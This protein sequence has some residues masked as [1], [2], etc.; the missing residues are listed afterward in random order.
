MSFILQGIQSYLDSYLP[1]NSVGNFFREMTQ[2]STAAAAD[3][4][5]TAVVTALGLYGV[6]EEVHDVAHQSLVSLRTC[7]RRTREHAHQTR[8]AIENGVEAVR[9]TARDVR[10]EFEHIGD[11]AAEAGA[12]LYQEVLLP[13]ARFASRVAHATPAYIRGCPRRS[14]RVVAASH[15][16]MQRTA[17]AVNQEVRNIGTG[18]RLTGR[19][20]RVIPRAMATSIRSGVQR[21]R[22]TVNS[23]ARRLTIEAVNAGRSTVSTGIQV[24]QVVAAGVGNYG[25]E[26]TRDAIAYTMQ[27]SRQ[28][29]DDI[30]LPELEA[31]H[32]AADTVYQ[33]QLHQTRVVPI[34]ERSRDGAV[35]TS[36][37]LFTQARA[38][39]H[40]ELNPDQRLGIQRVREFV[41]R[42]NRE[43]VV[44]DVTKF[45]TD[46][47]ME[48]L[49]QAGWFQS[50]RIT[51][52][53]RYVIKYYFPFSRIFLWMF[54]KSVWLTFTIIHFTLGTLRRF[55]GLFH[56]EMDRH[57]E[58]LYNVTQLGTALDGARGFRAGIMESATRPIVESIIRENVVEYF[59]LAVQK[60]NDDRFAAMVYAWLRNKI[61]DPKLSDLTEEQ[62][63]SLAITTINSISRKMTEWIALLFGSVREK[64]DYFQRYG[65]VGV[66]ALMQ[67]NAPDLVD[68]GLKLVGVRLI[69]WVYNNDESSRQFLVNQLVDLTREFVIDQSADNMALFRQSIEELFIHLQRNLTPAYRALIMQRV[70]LHCRDTMN[71]ETL[72][73]I[74]RYIERNLPD[75]MRAMTDADLLYSLVMQ[76]VLTMNTA[77][78]LT[79][80]TIEFFTRNRQYIFDFIA[81]NIVETNLEHIEDTVENRLKFVR[82]I[83]E[84]LEIVYQQIPR[85]MWEFLR[86]QA[87]NHSTEFLSPDQAHRIGASIR[88][89][90]MPDATGVIRP[91]DFNTEFLKVLIRTVGSISQETTPHFMALAREKRHLVIRFLAN[92][93]VNSGMEDMIAVESRGIFEEFFYEL[94]TTILDRMD[95]DSLKQ[96]LNIVLEEIRPYLID[97]E[98][99]ALHNRVTTGL[100]A[101][102]ATFNASLIQI[103]SATVSH[104][105]PN[106]RQLIARSIADFTANYW[107]DN[108]IQ[109]EKCRD[110]FAIFD[111]ATNPVTE[112]YSLSRQALEHDM[113]EGQLSAL[114]HRLHPHAPVDAIRA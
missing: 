17:R 65:L 64:M 46:R 57:L 51:P 16:V 66:L 83:S 43:K 8:L 59:D 70:L 91:I 37:A 36:R 89:H 113:H 32:A 45:A 79:P 81:Q 53:V 93:Q 101:D 104:L 87:L 111:R 94:Y 29:Y 100:P 19:I 4:A 63:H 114:L 41:G 72:A 109:A 54:D 5:G 90:D 58:W 61:D 42:L 48:L 7:P 76:V 44:N 92:L 84:L 52:A 21:V 15:A 80:R 105:T 77:E 88:A 12:D 28:A 68:A 47:G 20:I 23:S 9:E 86:G 71:P 38:A 3:P 108:P 10:G 107:I 6:A 69:H 78:N 97:V 30:V 14:R 24:A 102:R 35:V 98:Y 112:V 82:A 50:G 33:N 2:L 60:I 62:I 1:H 99:N 11:M 25:L 95:Q 40:R 13:S 75:T 110:V 22:R 73:I 67:R 106:V 85:N 26:R 74:N 39:A 31:L 27:Q 18:L 34:V 49:S 103:L 55:L 56:R 96:L